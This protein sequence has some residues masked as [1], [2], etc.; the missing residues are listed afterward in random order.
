[1]QYCSLDRLSGLQLNLSSVAEHAFL[2]CKL[3]LDLVTFSVIFNYLILF[4]KADIY[5]DLYINLNIGCQ[6][7]LVEIMKKEVT[8]FMAD[9]LMHI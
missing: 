5:T 4:L 2:D 7:A 6:C 1:M 9:I 3:F 8:R